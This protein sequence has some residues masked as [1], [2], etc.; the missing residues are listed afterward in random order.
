VTN[1]LRMSCTYASCA[2]TLCTTSAV[3]NSASRKARHSCQ[4]EQ[5]IDSHCRVHCVR[6]VESHGTVPAAGK[7]AGI[8]PRRTAVMPVSH[9]GL[10]A[11]RSRTLGWDNRQ[12]KLA[13]QAPRQ[14]MRL[15]GVHRIRGFDRLADGKRLPRLASSPP[16]MLKIVMSNESKRTNKALVLVG[17]NINAPARS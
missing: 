14:A 4:Q 3:K 11:T 9:R 13:R 16:A 17:I 1:P 8:V 12:H 10:L 7:S 5:T 2:T 6:G 15:H